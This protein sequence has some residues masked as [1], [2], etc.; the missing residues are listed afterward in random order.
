M[1]ELRILENVKNNERVLDIGAGDLSLARRLVEKGAAVTAIDKRNPD[2]IPSGVTFYLGDAQEMQQ[3]I[4]KEEL[5]DVIIALNV[6]QF[7]E[8]EYVLTEMIPELVRRMTHNGKIY[9]ET[10]SAP[11]VPSFSAG[12]LK[13]FYIMEDFSYFNLKYQAT[14][15]EQIKEADQNVRM[16]SFTDVIIAND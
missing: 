10:F 2:I 1:L 15:K 4:S 12:F 14:G 11:P 13:S 8:K 3:F 6:I 5:F 9:I 16:F 7:L